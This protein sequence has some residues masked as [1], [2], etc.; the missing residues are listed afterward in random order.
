MLLFIGETALEKELSMKFQY[1][2]CYSLS[3]TRF[4][5]VYFVTVSIHPMLLFIDICKNNY[6]FVYEFQYIPC[7]SLSITKLARRMEEICFNTSHVT[8]Y[9]L[10]S[11]CYLAG[12]HVSIHPM[13]LFIRW[14]HGCWWLSHYVSIHPMLLF[15]PSFYRLFFF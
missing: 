10:F 12:N 1:I 13:L 7:Y 3:S 11:D 6:V 2:P 8:L 5:Q 4:K 15:I 14:T 9:L